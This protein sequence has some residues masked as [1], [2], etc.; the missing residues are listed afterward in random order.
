ML[1]QV[2]NKSSLFGPMQQ[3]LSMIKDRLFQGI[4]EEYNVTNIEIVMAVIR[5][6]ENFRITREEL[7][8]TRLGKHINDLR[9]RTSDKA[10]A[11]RAKALVK[12]WRALLDVAPKEPEKD[13]NPPPGGGGG[14]AGAVLVGGAGANLANGNPAQRL[15]NNHAANVSPRLQGVV[16]NSVSPALR[17]TGAQVH[18]PRPL[19]SSVSS[20]KGVRPPP[21]PSLQQ[22]SVLGS[23]S[24]TS[25]VVISSTSTSPSYSVSRPS[26]P[27]QPQHRTPSPE[28]VELLQP[29]VK[30]YK[31]AGG[32]G[33]AQGHKR[34]RHALDQEVEIVDLEEEEEEREKAASHHLQASKRAKLELTNGDSRQSESST[35]TNSSSKKVN[36]LSDNH[37][38]S[39]NR[40][41]KSVKRPSAKSDASNILNR[42]M[43][44]AHK[45][46]KV[47]TTQELVQNLGIESRAASVSPNNYVTDLVPNENKA[48]LMN[49]FFQSQREPTLA[50]TASAGQ[51]SG[52]EESSSGAATPSVGPASRVTTPAVPPEGDKGESI[53]DILSKLPPIDPA[54]VLAEWEAD[55][56][57]DD[58][59][60]EGL[61]PVYKPPQEIT[62]KLIEDLNEGQLEHIGGIRDHVGEFKEWHELVSLESKDGEL[63]HILPYSVID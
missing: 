34:N 16:R 5:E 26:S 22:K 39:Q 38:H 59:D 50:E 44:M 23:G 55:H 27:A 21:S 57:D 8:A 49:R 13:S 52:D 35:A 47:R 61:I 30:P 31:G 24:R 62:P 15:A 18:S 1:V 10:L 53:E 33:G 17:G 63:L 4:D 43:Q 60:A 19:P 28:V 9:R 45:A 14:V 6:L 11:T 36:S 37:H 29:Q 12:N 46:G 7:E 41:K 58:I 42:Q 32:G 54:A 3:E 56:E 48:E 20:G 40:P 51:S 2:S 25:P